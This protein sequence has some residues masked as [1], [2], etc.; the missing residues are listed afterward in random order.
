[1]NL[2][3]FKK[4]VLIIVTGLLTACVSA[5]VHLVNKTVINDSYT[6]VASVESS[7]IE[8]R[9]IP[10]TIDSKTYNLETRLSI[11]AN[12]EGKLPLIVVT[13]GRSGPSP[14]R[15]VRSVHGH[16]VQSKALMSAGYA[17]LYVVRRGYGNSDGPDSEYLD[18]P[19]ESAIE[20]AKD[21][22]GVIEY[23][24]NNVHGLN[25]VSIDYDRIATYGVSQGGWVALASSTLDIKGL[26]AVVNMSGAINFK[27]Q[28]KRAR[29]YVTESAL[30][31]SASHLGKNSK[32]PSFWLYAENDNHSIES[33][34]TWMDTFQ[35]NGGKGVLY[36]TPAY[37]TKVT[38]GGH[39]VANEPNYYFAELLAFLKANGM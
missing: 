8:F 23:M 5:P 27:K 24:R 32:V 33:V 15:N 2:L 39:A 10:V 20:G 6:S 14:E 26:K 1:M 28:G 38:N 31:K 25:K 16:M 9:T 12:V 19:E 36:K 17:V 18:T 29:D 22:A 34:S 30:E 3:N 7:D 37:R 11:P 13:H 4:F 21:L 35:K